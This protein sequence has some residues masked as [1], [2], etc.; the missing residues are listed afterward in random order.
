MTLQYSTY[1]KVPDG[2]FE[3]IGFSENV[4]FDI[5]DLV[6]SLAYNTLYE[7]RVD[8]HDDETDLTTTGDVWGFYT[9][10]D[11]D[12]VYPR[13]RGYNPNQVWDVFTQSWVDMASFD[14]TGGGRLLNR[15]VVVGHNCVYYGDA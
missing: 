8:V 11:P 2:E 14:Y 13:I 6:S 9:Q 12:I 1:F 10:P 15:V 3:L 7:W 5:S 4:E